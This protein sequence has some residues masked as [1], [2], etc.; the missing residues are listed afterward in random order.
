MVIDDGT[1]PRL[2]EQR[3]RWTSADPSLRWITQNTTGLR[4]RRG[5]GV[6][7]DGRA[8]AAGADGRARAAGVRRC[9]RRHARYFRLTHGR[10]AGV[11]VDISEPDTPATSATRSGCPASTRRRRVGRADGRRA[12]V[13][14]EA[15]GHA[16]ARRG[17][18][19]SRPAAARRGLRRQPQGVDSRRSGTRRTRWGC[20]DSCR[21]TRVRLSAVPRL[22][23][24]AAVV[25]AGRS[26]VSRSSGRRSKR[27][28]RRVGLA[29]VAPAATSRVP[30]RCSGAHGRSDAQRRPP[31]RRR[32]KRLI[33]LA[34]IDAP[35]YEQGTR[36]EFEITVEGVRHFVGAKVVPTPFF[37]PSRKTQRRR[38][39]TFPLSTFPFPLA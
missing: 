33:A 28:T 26:S 37:N 5:R 11:P 2:D 36:V 6:G 10:I 7:D 29:P 22:S 34:T 12:G 35:H 19:R 4:V 23:R 3:F 9:R 24:S 15:G 8:G 39:R 20:R 17:A 31:G 18:H 21:S 38:P 30:C 25:R 1:V 27:C 16:R 14:V 13:R 32:L